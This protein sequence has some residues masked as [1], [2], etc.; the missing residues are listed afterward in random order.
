MEERQ[1]DFNQP[2][3]SV[4]RF[5]AGISTPKAENKRKTDAAVSKLPPLPAYKS[6]FKSGPVSKPGKVP[7][8]WEQT[9][10]RPKNGDKSQSQALQ[11]LPVAPKLPPGRAFNAK[12]INSDKGYKGMHPT[13][14]QALNVQS[15][16][17]NIQKEESSVEKLEEIGSCTS[18]DS[19]ESYVDALDALSQTESSF[20]NCSISGLSGLD[21][22][23]VKPS[24]TFASDPQTRDFMM[25][26]FLP[27]AK[28]VASEIPQH[29]S[30]K[31]PV[32]RE[33][34]RQIKDIVVT[35]RRQMPD[36]NRLI[37]IPYNV[38]CNEFEESEDEDNGYDGRDHSSPSVCGLFPRLCLQSSFCL[39]NPVPGIKRQ[40][41]RPI[42]SVHK[43]KFQSSNVVLSKK[44]ENKNPTKVVY[45]RGRTSH[46]LQPAGVHEH[47]DELN[48][49]SKQILCTRDIMKV[50][51]SPLYKS[52]QNK[53]SL[54]L[55][56]DF[57]QSAVTEEK[58]VLVSHEK[59]QDS[60]VS[61]SNSPTKHVRTFQ[62]LLVDDMNQQETGCLSPMVE[63][64]LYIDSVH[65]NKPQNSSSSDTKMFSAYKKNDANTLI[66]ASGIEEM[67]CMSSSVKD[68]K[69][70]DGAGE[71]KKVRVESL[72]SVDS[73][74][75]SVSDGSLH[76]VQMDVM[77]SSGQDQ[78]LLQRSMAS[79]SPKVNKNGM[80]NIKSRQD[81]NA[82]NLESSH[83][84]T[85]D[86][87]MFT[88]ARLV[89]DGKINVK[90]QVSSGI[91]NQENT[92][93]C[94]SLLPLPPPLPNSPTE[95]WL[96]RTL[97]AVS[98]KNLFSRSSFV[99]HTT[100]RALASKR[101]SLEVKWETIAKSS[102]EL[103]DS[104]FSE[105]LLAP[106]SEA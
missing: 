12:P 52:W 18:D 71:K 104:R 15:V 95:S 16:D 69:F 59:F 35:Q 65:T 101:E 34:P 57:S 28:A 48:S 53:S 88:R 105:E 87:I 39:L 23:D 98:S 31:P 103:G 22:S 70:L 9:P 83:G 27:A 17:I 93:P 43:T 86:P 56:N 5:S 3:L 37:N 97:P 80:I 4:R 20:Y 106:I 29:F 19:D 30:K 102:K 84:L 96:M 21:A 40:A 44:I 81:T 91:I 60:K 62:E 1:L 82:G 50:D 25:G 89:D 41:Q 75:L 8:V 38:Q 2:F 55:Y 49:V 85:H 36:Q 67:A 92:M 42:S 58:G 33:Q 79:P 76:D 24:G 14:L 10:G 74:F 90:G 68:V 51:G 26:R 73:G 11:K 47:K 46:G 6:D 32:A 66:K 13:R 77:D 78:D 72:E 61:S 94:H 7:F 54:P 45:E 64:T 99:T 100:P 63:K